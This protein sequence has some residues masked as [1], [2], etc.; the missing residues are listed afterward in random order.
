VPD[1]SAA[2]VAVLERLLAS[3]RGE[4]AAKPA[5]K[6]KRRSLPVF[7][8]EHELDALL[9]AVP[10]ERDRLLV[11]MMRFAGLRV[12]EA[13]KM[14]VE[15]LEFYAEPKQGGAVGLVRVIEGKG[16]KDRNVPMHPQL[17]EPLREWLGERRSGWLFESPRYPGRF[18]SVR[19]VERMV[20]VATQRAG[21][22][23]HVTPHKL[24]HSF[25]TWLLRKGAN[26]RQV[27]M[28]LGHSSVAITEIYTHITSD[29]L[30]AVIGLA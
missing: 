18:Y 13:C 5:R 9:A 29:E 16:G 27:Q 24:R 25:A 2:D 21:I 12:S 11:R 3:A 4:T 7:L 23:K 28:L 6:K 30:D 8:T 14:R 26:L 10:F 15:H 17:L 22:T 20:Q 1:I 19:G